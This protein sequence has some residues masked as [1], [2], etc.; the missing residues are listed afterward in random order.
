VVP[1]AA[2]QETGCRCSPALFADHLEISYS[3]MPGFVHLFL[4]VRFFLFARS[5]GLRRQAPS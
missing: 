2:S 3:N 1:S 4:F 5:T